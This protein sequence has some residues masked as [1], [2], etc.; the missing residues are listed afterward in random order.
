[1]THCTSKVVC[2][3]NPNNSHAYMIGKALVRLDQPHL[4]TEVSH[5]QAGLE[6]VDQIK[7]Q[8]ADT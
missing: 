8:L 1:M 7:K 3:N 5:L 6:R 4:T 2:V